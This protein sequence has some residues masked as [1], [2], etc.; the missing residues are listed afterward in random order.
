MV[1]T[2]RNHNEVQQM[3][4]PNPADRQRYPDGPAAVMDKV[5][6]RTPHYA[7]VA[8]TFAL[9][10]L[11]THADVQESRLRYSFRMMVARLDYF[12]SNKK[13]RR[14]RFSR[15]Q[16][17]AIRRAL[18]QLEIDVEAEAKRHPRMQEAAHSI[19]GSRVL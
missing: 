7:T 17:R 6:L 5:T 8:T 12:S 2:D 14:L 18:T 15:N 4:I 1:R 13:L 9:V 19:G 3:Y 11:S 10:I 16:L